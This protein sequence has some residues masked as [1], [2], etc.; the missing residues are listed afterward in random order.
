MGCIAIHFSCYNTK[1]YEFFDFLKVLIQN[2]Y[3]LS[4]LVWP[5]SATVVLRKNRS[6]KS[7]RRHGTKTFISFFNTIN[8][9]KDH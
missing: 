5:V 6:R 7:I 1:R 4:L 9:Q 3:L 2:S 8:E